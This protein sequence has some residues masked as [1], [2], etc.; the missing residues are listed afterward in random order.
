MDT[1]NLYIS[2]YNRFCPTAEYLQADSRDR[3]FLLEG[4][5][6]AGLALA[7][8]AFAE[9]FFGS[10]GEAAAKPIIIKIKAFGREGGLRILGFVIQLTMNEA[11]WAEALKAM[12]ADRVGGDDNDK[13][14][15]RIDQFPGTVLAFLVKKGEFDILREIFRL[16]RLSIDG[17]ARR[18]MLNA[19]NFDRW[20]E[21]LVLL[22]AYLTMHRWLPLTLETDGVAEE[23]GSR[24]ELNTAGGGRFAHLFASVLGE[25]ITPKH[26]QNMAKEYTRRET[27][28][29][30][31][32]RQWLALGKSRF[33]I[34]PYI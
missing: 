8:H 21:D 28:S 33:E 31:D 17:V 1:E 7:M 10:L 16:V 25:H 11:Q 34:A 3:N 30:L 9:S 2:L 26:Q 4:I 18:A 23:S 12:S 15:L 14:V 29:R 24:I 5:I 32:A 22:M 20:I 6:I 27:E 19:R 13:E